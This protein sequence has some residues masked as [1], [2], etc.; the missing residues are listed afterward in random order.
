M[1]NTGNAAINQAKPCFYWIFI[2][3]R[4]AFIHSV[5]LHS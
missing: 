2:I 1:S 3:K 5:V 4:N